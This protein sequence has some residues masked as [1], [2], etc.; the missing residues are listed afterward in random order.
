LAV[1]LDCDRG[2][3]LSFVCWIEALGFQSAL[4]AEFRLVLSFISV[5]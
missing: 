3:T 4:N 2:N 5:V 1:P